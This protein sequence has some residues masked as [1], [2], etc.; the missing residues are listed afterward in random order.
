MSAGKS[1]EKEAFALECD[2]D[3]IG[4]DDVG[5]L[6]GFKDREALRAHLTTTYPDMTPGRLNNW[7]VQIWTFCAK[8]KNGHLI[9]LPLKGQP[10]VAFGKVVGDDYPYV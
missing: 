7:S 2:H 6:S 3:V 4:W 8:I 1:G 10:A 9:A 5:D